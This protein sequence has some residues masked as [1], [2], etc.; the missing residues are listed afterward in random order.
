MG[1]GYPLILVF[2]L[3]RSMMYNEEIMGLM[4][5]QVNDAI[6]ARESNAIAFFLPT[7]GAERIECI[8]PVQVEEVEMSRI[9]GIVEDLVKNFD[10]GQGADEGKDDE[11]NIIDL[12]GNQ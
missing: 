3:D 5:K 9:N 8:N 7:D 4:T 12:D 10:V 2:Y 6:A 11:S 1:Q